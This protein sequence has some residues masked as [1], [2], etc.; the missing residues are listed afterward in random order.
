MLITSPKVDISPVI[1]RLGAIALD[2]ALEIKAAK[3]L[4]PADGPSFGVA[5]IGTWRWY[6]FVSKFVQPRSYKKLKA[7]I[8]TT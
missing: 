8:F 4:T 2:V 6:E 1:A 3:R 5:P 7:A